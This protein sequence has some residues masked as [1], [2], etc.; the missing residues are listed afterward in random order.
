MFAKS[1][2]ER[3]NFVVEYRG[4]LIKSE[5]AERR[6]RV[7]HSACAVFMFDFH[8]QETNCGGKYRIRINFSIY[9]MMLLNSLIIKLKLVR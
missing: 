2:F 1:H 8:W 3:G 6:R 5:E 7:Y 9:S 4:Q